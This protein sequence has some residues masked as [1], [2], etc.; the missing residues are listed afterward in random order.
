[1]TLRTL[2]RH[3][4]PGQGEA[5]RRMVEGCVRPGHGR[6]TGVASPGESCLGMVGVSGA[7]VVLQVTGRAGTAGQSV[8]SVHVTLGAGQRDVRSGQCESHGRVVKGRASPGR[9]AVATLASLW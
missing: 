1:V 9:G 2:Q 3:V 8:I 6:V 7:P 4:C 5:G